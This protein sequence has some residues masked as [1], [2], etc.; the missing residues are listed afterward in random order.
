MILTGDGKL[1]IGTVTPNQL[2]EVYGTN[3]A[4]VIRGAEENNTATLFLGTGTQGISAYKCAIIAEGI[5]NWSRSTLHF[6]L[7]NAG[8]PPLTG[9]GYNTY[10][11]YNATIADAKMSILRDGTVG[12]GNTTP[13]ALLTVGNPTIT[14][15][16]GVLVLS[17]NNGTS[18]CNFKFGFD[19]SF[20]FNMGSYGTAISGNTQINQFIIESGSLANSLLLKASGNVD[21]VSD[22]S[23]SSTKRYCSIGG[24]RIAGW[25]TTNTI[26]NTSIL[27][28]SALSNITFNTGTTTANLTE[29][30]RITT[31]GKIG[32]NNKSP[33]LTL[34]IGSTNANHN[35]G[36][37][38]LT[39]GNIHAADKLDFLSIGR[40]DGGSIADWEF[41]GIKYGVIT[42]AAAGEGA[43]NHTCMT[44]HTWGNNI[45]TSKEV[46]RLTSR[47]RLGLNTTSPQYLL[48]VNGTINSTSLYQNGVLI[49]FSSYLVKTVDNTL[50]GS[51]TVTSS[52][53]NNQILLENT[54]TNTYCSIRFKNNN[55]K[56]GY[57]GIG[58]TGLTQPN[59]YVNNVYL[60]ANNAIIFNTAQAGPSVPRMILDTSGNVGIATTNPTNILQVGNAGRLK[61]GS[62]TT[63]YTLLGTI[64][65]D[66]PTNTRIVISGNTRP[67]YSGKIEYVTT[68]S[69]GHHCFITTS[70]NTNYVDRMRILANGN[71]GIGNTIPMGMLNI[72]TPDK[73]AVSNSDG[74][75]IISKNNG[76][77]GFHNYKIGFDDAFNFCIGDYGGSA[78]TNTWRYADLNISYSTGN[79]GIGT[80]GQSQKLNVNGSVALTSFS[81]SSSTLTNILSLNLDDTTLNQYPPIA[82]NAATTTIA[83]Q[84]YGN[85]IYTIA[86][87]SEL[88]VYYAYNLFNYMLDTSIWNTAAT[89]TTTTGIYSGSTT[90]TIIDIAYLGEWV[91]FYYNK[92]FVLKKI[93][94]IG[95]TGYYSRAPKN[96]W[97]VASNNATNWILLSTQT[98]ITSYSATYNPVFNINNFTNYKYYRI[99]IN[100]TNGMDA[101]LT[102]SEIQLYGTPNTTYTN[103]D[104]FNTTF[105]NTTE[106]QFPPRLYDS[107]TAET[108]TATEI[109]NCNP[110]T[111]YKQTLT[112]SNHG[113]YTIYSSSTDNISTKYLLF[114]YNISSTS[115]GGHWYWNGSTGTYTSNDGT[116]NGTNYINSDYI[117]DWIIV[118][119]PYK[120]VL[121][122]F[123][124]YHRTN[125]IVVPSRA[126]G[127]WKCYGSNDGITFTEI[128]EASNSITS[129]TI[130]HYAN[131]Y[132]EFNV[133]SLFDIPY[134]YIG[135]T[136]NKL[137][138]GDASAYIL[139]F[140]E[141]QIFGKDDI[142]N[143]YSKVWNWSLNNNIIF[144]NSSTVTN[145][146]GNTG[147]INLTNTY[148]KINNTDE[149]YFTTGSSINTTFSNGVCTINSTPAITNYSYPLLLDNNLNIIN[150]IIW[151]K[152][153]NGFLLNDSGS[154]NNG[155]LIAP[156]APAAATI[157]TA[158]YIKNGASAVFLASSSQY[159]SLP[160]TV[161]FNLINITTG[162]SFS[163][164]ARINATGSGNYGRIF[165]FGEISSSN[166]INYITIARDGAT[167]NLIFKIENNASVGVS[168]TIN[169][170]LDNVWRHY[171]WTI[172]ITGVWMLYVNNVSTNPAKTQTIPIVAKANRTYNLGKSLFSAD[173][174]LNMN[175]DDFRI[176][177]KVLSVADVN[178]LYL[179]RVSVY[180]KL[181]IGI[182]TTNPQYIL[183]VNGNTNIAGDIILNKNVGIGTNTIGAKLHIV[184]TTGSI[185]SASTGTIILDHQNNYGA[186]SIVFRSTFNRNNDYGYIQYQDS[187][188]YNRAGDDSSK[189][190][191]GTKSASDDDILLL[192]SGGVGIGTTVVQ[193]TNELTVYGYTN[194]T[195]NLRVAGNTHI[196]GNISF[197]TN[198]AAVFKNNTPFAMYFAEDY[199]SGATLPNYLANGKDATI[200]G[201]VT[202]VIG[203]GN[204]TTVTIPYLTGPSTSSITFATGSVPTTFTIAGIIRYNGT[205][206]G[207]ILVADSASPW[208]LG[209][210]NGVR[211]TCYNNTFTTTSSLISRGNQDDWL[212]IA[213][214]NSGSTGITTL[215][216]G[217]ACGTAT[218]TGGY[219]LGINTRG[220]TSS[221]AFSCIMIW[222]KALTDAEMILL[223]EMMNIY[224]KT[225]ISIKQYLYNECA[226]ENRNYDATKQSELLLF[227]GNNSNIINGY[228][229]IRIKA[230]SILFDTFNTITSD[231]TLL[232]NL[233]VIDSSGNVG[234]GT[235]VPTATLD[236]RG[237]TNIQLAT[238]ATPGIGTNGSGGGNRIILHP[239]TNTVYPYSIGINGSMLWF[240]CPT[241]A[242]HAFYIGGSKVMNIDSTQYLTIG[243]ATQT[244]G[245]IFSDIA[246]A[247]W[248]LITD[249]SNLIIYNGTT[250][251]TFNELFKLTPGGN[252]GIGKTNPNNKLHIS[253]P[254]PCLL[255]VDTNISQPNE[256]AGIEFGIPAFSTANTA[257]ITST[258]ISGNVTDLKFYTAN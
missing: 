103:T 85:G 117:G 91:Q 45:W 46:M 226:I 18:G 52:T 200:S 63:D 26:Y 253:G 73:N 112:L 234:I 178:E 128:T 25:D 13:M 235:S 6:C 216:D 19:S 107:F 183:D 12:I 16:D 81:D 255:R 217:L 249:N 172:T 222:D 24:L 154:L 180:K 72:G 185:A 105:Y 212:C 144:N 77:G 119:L 55:V 191:I 129:L 76:G 188:I 4:M 143:S 165:D 163:F 230:P 65:T 90:T 43:N 151:Y 186:S 30:M 3:P 28:L 214:K 68:S 87:S 150:P 227:K 196:G 209:H 204:G 193:T 187:S 167:N 96:L 64:D 126:P 247:S 31:D 29:Q 75:I 1:G 100:A 8:N 161:D 130:N 207:T 153:D 213:S 17:K 80:T 203:S 33:N 250:G 47:G 166:G 170:Q 36:R 22:T 74:T 115:P 53:T 57:I 243:N 232:N 135:W 93:I 169:S 237:I 158:N 210:Y 152:F 79:I 101:T 108:T 175:L 136:I 10:P 122:R 228:D 69:T 127:L 123:R 2:F 149:Y 157:D 89:Y 137:A 206:R 70:D 176:Y 190:I 220:T 248:K 138:G 102:I 251:G 56:Y 132:Y 84:T 215:I 240:G 5:T 198:C 97:I 254:S 92:G 111:V 83:N 142:C 41:S 38:I 173:S 71:I 104:N 50:T 219:T 236:V 134:Q 39:A 14:N 49:N 37:A 231:K 110:S 94:I 106:K 211:G 257:K 238:F 114:D 218:G 78:I 208:W 124:F 125:V 61:I 86:T 229:R 168:T 140:L 245:V 146:I 54:G 35:I 51:L 162:I 156:T 66:G 59:Y 48:D 82:I 23:S 60:E 252:L 225:G 256:V 44:F 118:K 21:I 131:G 258:A 171:V 184:E 244:A 121:T 194:I 27:G 11:T 224:L 174:Y 195:D 179:G 192:P 239:G 67:G 246:G 233:T 9:S 182:G 42:G 159:L 164:W 15:S 40:W 205:P 197:G 145:Y 99:I 181:N 113:I 141:L 241:N 58:C 120:M 32:I 160:T 88:G 20:N 223:A 116:Y 177:N 62:G 98:N 109:F 221:Y 133:N 147:N 148:V 139:N 95:Y 202:K 201:T 7:N 189:L 199:V 34:D 155:S 242:Q